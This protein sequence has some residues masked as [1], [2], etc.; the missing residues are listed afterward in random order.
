MGHGAPDTNFN[1]QG[2]V[3]GLRVRVVRSRDK[4]CDRG[5]RVMREPRVALGMFA[6]NS[7]TKVGVVSDGELDGNDW[8]YRPGRSGLSALSSSLGTAEVAPLSPSGSLSKSLSGGAGA[9]SDRSRTQV[10]RDNKQVAA[11]LR[12]G[13]TAVMAWSCHKRR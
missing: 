13:R 7:G 2:R 1:Y 5:A 8:Q 10:A 9:A 4:A 11:D 6:P 12:C 3:E